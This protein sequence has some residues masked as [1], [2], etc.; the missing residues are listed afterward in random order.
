[1]YDLY[2]IRYNQG[3]MYEKPI[4]L[5]GPINSLW[6]F[7]NPAQV[8]E[9]LRPELAGRAQN[10]DARRAITVADKYT[11]AVPPSSGYHVF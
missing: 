10:A 5:F 2:E 6:I 3:S 7:Q 9:V 11:G 4:I 1:M 8:T